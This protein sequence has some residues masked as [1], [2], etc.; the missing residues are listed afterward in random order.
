MSEK[1]TDVR[2]FIELQWY[3]LND[4]WMLYCITQ[5]GMNCLLLV[6]GTR[7]HPEEE[8]GTERR[9]IRG[10]KVLSN[11]HSSCLVNESDC[12]RLLLYSGDDAL[13][14][15]TSDVTEGLRRTLQLLQSEV[16]RSLVSNELLGTVLPPSTVSVAP[17]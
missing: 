6:G 13:M 12:S 16:D 14:S 10:T 5:I 17:H 4:N 9:I 15:A 7:L 11:Y 3:N 8:E 1:N 2:N